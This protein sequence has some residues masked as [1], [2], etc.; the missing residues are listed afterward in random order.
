MRLTKK[1]QTEV[2]Q[3]DLT[4]MIDMTFQLI[5]FFMVLINF[6]QSVQ[7]QRVQL[8]DSSLAKPAELPLDH[9]VIIHLAEDGEA[10]YSGQKIPIGGLGPYLQKE[11]RA[12]EFSGDG[13][14]AATIV[15]RAHRFCQAGRVQELIEECQ[16]VGF[17]N[18]ALRAQENIETAKYLTQ[19]N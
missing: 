19:P 10:I 18:F 3:G 1:K 8:P 13:V 14:E 15:I 4:P 6:T 7:E 11:I 2:A 16:E 17:E 12:L 9:P 5:A